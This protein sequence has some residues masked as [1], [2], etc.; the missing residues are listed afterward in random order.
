VAVACLLAAGASFTESYRAEAGQRHLV[1]AHVT[2]VAMPIPPTTITNPATPTTTPASPVVVAPPT[3]LDI[4]AVGLSAS[5]V[6][7]GLE[8]GGQLEMPIP[9]VAGWYRSGPAPGAVGPAVIVGH[10]DTFKGP[11]VFYPL[12]AV[13]PG[14]QVVIVRADH[15]RARFVITGVTIVKKAAFPTRAVFAPTRTASIRLITCTGTFNV[16]S[17]HYVD[18]LIAWGVATN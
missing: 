16:H 18:S 12:T 5:V 4:P 2:R 6:P 8:G 13:R 1:P 14:D 10:V 9:S 17:R 7:V 3:H 11:A 15:S